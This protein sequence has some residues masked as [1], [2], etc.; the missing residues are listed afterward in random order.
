MPDLVCAAIACVRAVVLTAQKKT[1]GLNR[2]Q[3]C[4]TNSVFQRHE[5]QTKLRKGDGQHCLQVGIERGPTE[6]RIEIVQEE[7]PSH[8]TPYVACNRAINATLGHTSLRR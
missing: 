5:G 8:E 3:I 1:I 2:V 7:L 4:E 6:D